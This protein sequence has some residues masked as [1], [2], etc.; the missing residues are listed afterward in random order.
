M[1]PRRRWSMKW[2][3]M[4]RGAKPRCA[5]CCGP[6][7][8][9]ISSSIYHVMDVGGRDHNSVMIRNINGVLKKGCWGLMVP[10]RARGG[11]W[12]IKFFI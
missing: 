3:G 11:N 8:G 9:G 4:E 2:A 10:V 5:R 1:D 6:Y 7:N 12:L